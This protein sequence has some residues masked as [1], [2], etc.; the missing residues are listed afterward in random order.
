[1]KTLDPLKEEI[2]IDPPMY[3]EITKVINYLR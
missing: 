3:K 2:D 1:M